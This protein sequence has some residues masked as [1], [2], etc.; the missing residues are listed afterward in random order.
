MKNLDITQTS[1]TTKPFESAAD[2]TLLWNKVDLITLPHKKKDRYVAGFA[3]SDRCVDRALR[4]RYEVFNLELNEGLDESAVT[5]LDRD[6]YDDQM[7]HLVLLEPSTMAIVGTYRIQTMLHAQKYRGLYSAQEYDLSP[8]D[9][10][11]DQTLELG[12]ACLAMEHRTFRAIM[13]I[14]LGI[15]AYMNMYDQRYLFGCSSLTSQDPDDGWRAMKTI[16]KESYL[17]SD[18]MLQALWPYNCGA[19][20]REFD[21]DLGDAVSLPKLFRTYLRLGSKVISEPAIDREFG[22]VD[23]LVFQDVQAIALSKLDVLK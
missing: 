22:T 13:T 2:F 20:S 12:R 18:L 1:L 8:L 7:T 21:V 10:Y 19:V 6:E 23:F 9:L 4:L 3:N 14:W 15:G 11:F 5:G 16:R 17:H